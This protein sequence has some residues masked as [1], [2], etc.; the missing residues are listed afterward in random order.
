LTSEGSTFPSTEPEWEDSTL[1]GV[2]G[3]AVE[4]LK[5]GATSNPN[6]VAGAIAAVIR[7]GREAEIHAIGAGAVNQGVKAI[8]VARGYLAQNGID[9][10]FIPAFSEIEIDGT[11]RTAVK[12]LIR[13]R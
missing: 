12:L 5:V 2:R 11:P 13:A 1:K 4:T 8:V 9:L 7:S 6:T 3:V 10:C